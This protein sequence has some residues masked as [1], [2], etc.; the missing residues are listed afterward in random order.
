MRE[1][2]SIRL[3]AAGALTLALCCTFAGCSEKRPIITGGGEHKVVQILIRAYA[4]Q[5]SAKDRGPVSLIVGER[6]QLRVFAAWAIPYVSEQTEKAAWTVSDAAVG[7]VDKNGVFTARK[8]GRTVV[9][10]V[11]RVADNGAGDVLGPGQT[12]S[13]GPVKTFRD[14]LELNVREETS[15]APK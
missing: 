2:R 15:A 11:I 14:E 3:A 1:S 5:A 13:N 10:A 6:L 7:D 12:A 4:K 8:A 9:T